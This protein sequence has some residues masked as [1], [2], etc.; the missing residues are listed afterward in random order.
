M[1]WGSARVYCNL[2]PF[3]CLSFFL[4]L[5]IIHTQ[6]SSFGAKAVVLGSRVQGY[7]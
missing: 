4:S 1:D 6:R 2:F 7:T 3:P 5:L